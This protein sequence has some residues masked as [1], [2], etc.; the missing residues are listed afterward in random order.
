MTAR[1]IAAFI[2]GLIVVV[3][4]A[5]LGRKMAL[6][7]IA[8]NFTLAFIVSVALLEGSDEARPLG[9]FIGLMHDILL[10]KYFG[11]YAMIYYLVA[12]LAGLI[13]NGFKSSNLLFLLAVFSAFDLGYGVVNYFFLHFIQ[14]RIDVLYY[15]VHVILAEL[16]Y[17][18]PFCILIFLPTK[19]ISDA[20]HRREAKSRRN[21]ALTG[22]VM[23]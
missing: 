9:F 12:H 2:I 16:V 13:H 17:S 15:L 11:F 14:G 6:N 4:E 10:A 23:K 19:G 18:L 5:T 7:G 8:P 3:F 22:I 1:R 20:W 21:R